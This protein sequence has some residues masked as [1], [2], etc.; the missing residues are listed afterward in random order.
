MIGSFRHDLSSE[1]RAELVPDPKVSR[2]E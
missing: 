2:A 1:R